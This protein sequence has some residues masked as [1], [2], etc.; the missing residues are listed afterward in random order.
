[1]YHDQEHHTFD[2]EAS[3]ALIPYEPPAAGSPH[4]QKRHPFLLRGAA[5]ALCCCL[6]GGGAGA[7]AVWSMSGGGPLAGPRGTAVTPVVL[8]ST[9]SG[10]A[11]SN[12]EIYAAA[13][14]SVVSINTTI[15]Q[16]GINIFGQP[17]QAAS[18]GSGF[19][20]CSDGYILT[21][22][23]VVQDASAVEVTTY[24]GDVFRAQVIGGDPDYDIAVLKVAA[25]GLQGASLGDSDTLNVGDRV[26]AIGNPLGELTFSMSG[27]MVS[28]VNRAI[29]VS[30]TPFHMIQTDTSINPGNSGGPLLNTS[31]EVVGIV[32]AKYSSSNGKIVEGI[33]FAIPINDVRAMVQDIIDNGYVTNK[34]YLGVTAGTVNAQMAQQAGLAQGVYL[35]AVDPNGAAAAAGLRTGDIITQ[36]D[37]TD[38]RSMTDLSAAKKSYSAGDTAQFTVIR[39]G[40]TMEPVGTAPVSYCSQPPASAVRFLRHLAEEGI[41]LPDLWRQ[42]PCD[43]SFL[44]DRLQPRRPIL[45]PLRIVSEACGKF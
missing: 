17:V 4:F 16:A 36:V 25:S 42:I 13:V 30:G 3:H 28:S 10:K 40:Q 39:G 15:S 43:L 33:G 14:N 27:G 12:A 29:N 24:S 6:L 34:A 22:Y 2:Q 11:M 7:G 38:I 18:S 1:M 20:L 26:L 41:L 45:R 37:G 9:T 31:G 8:N 21:N 44:W 23:H 32:S 35:Y 19:I 5:L